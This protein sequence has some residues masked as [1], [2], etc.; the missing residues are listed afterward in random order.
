MLTTITFKHFL[1]FTVLILSLFAWKNSW[2]FWQ[3]EKE[4]TVLE[5]GFW[6]VTHYQK[7]QDSGGYADFYRLYDIREHLK[8][9]LK[10]PVLVTIKPPFLLK[11]TSEFHAVM[12]SNAGDHFYPECMVLVEAYLDAR[13][14][15]ARR[16]KSFWIKSADDIKINE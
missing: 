10:P 13:G 8:N 1:V 9:S 12:H 4:N 14:Y 3:K 6:R 15:G 2:G 7:K 11:E 16:I 5:N